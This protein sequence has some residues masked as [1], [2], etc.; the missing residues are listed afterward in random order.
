MLACQGIAAIVDR[1]AYPAGNK[2]SATKR[3]CG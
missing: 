2:P 3:K 1:A